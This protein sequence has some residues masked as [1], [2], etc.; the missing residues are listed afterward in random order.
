LKQ[1]QCLTFGAS[2]WLALDILVIVL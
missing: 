2:T 1:A